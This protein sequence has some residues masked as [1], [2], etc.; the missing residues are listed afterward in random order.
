MVQEVDIGVAG[1]WLSAIRSGPVLLTAGGGSSS[2][3]VGL[4][5]DDALVFG[6]P[7][8]CKE[9]VVKLQKAFEIKIS[10]H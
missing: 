4:Y 8:L 3:L 5:V 9:C 6:T 10:A 7:D 1:D 2:V